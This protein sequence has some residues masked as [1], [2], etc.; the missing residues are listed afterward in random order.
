MG[1]SARVHGL[2]F[3]RACIS[4]GPDLFSHESFNMKQRQQMKLSFLLTA[5]MSRR[6]P[7]NNN[8]RNKT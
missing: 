3:E 2:S 5:E 8:F 4:T 6:Q 7:G 1:K